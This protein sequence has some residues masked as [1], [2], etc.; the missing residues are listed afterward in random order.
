MFNNNLM[1]R[2][3]LSLLICFFELNFCEVV[4]KEVQGFLTCICPL[5]ELN[6]S[7]GLHV[8]SLS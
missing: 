7:L 5:V 8:S 4:V 3:A 1:V 2:L 6:S